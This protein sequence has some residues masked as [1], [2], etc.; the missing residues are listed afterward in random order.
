ME[1]CVRL[2][3]G[4]RVPELLESDF[5][6]CL[7]RRI[8]WLLRL[9]LRLLRDGPHG[10][11]YSEQFNVSRIYRLPEDVQRMLESLLRSRHTRH[12]RHCWRLRVPVPVLWV[13]EPDGRS[14][15]T[16][17][18]D[19][20]RLSPRDVPGLLEPRGSADYAQC[21]SHVPWGVR[22]SFQEL[23]FADRCS[24]S[25]CDQ[26]Q[27]SIPV[28]G[29]VLKLHEPVDAS[30]RASGHDTDAKL[31]HIDV[32]RMHGPHGKSGY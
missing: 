31:L 3:P 13:H 26:L 8:H 32:R 6:G 19:G 2:R 27:R 11:S 22:W 14:G 12:H 20:E 18:E 24:D 10:C 28:S 9:E 30:A 21:D 15:D 5:R 1:Q 25:S 23:L 16:R 29:D 4:V 7:Y 17:F